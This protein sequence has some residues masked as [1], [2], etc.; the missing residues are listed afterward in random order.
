MMNLTAARFRLELEALEGMNLPPY[1]GSTFRGGF[2]GVFR[3]IACSRRLDKCNGCLLKNTCP[4]G[5]IFESGPWEGA[6]VWG[7]FE[8]I[9]RPF[10]IEP[11]ETAQTQF[12]AGERIDFHLVLIGKAIDYLPYFILVFKELGETGIGKGRAKFRLNRVVSLP[13][14]GMDGETVYD[15]ERVSNRVAVIRAADLRAEGERGDDWLHLVFQTMTRLKIDGAFVDLPEFPVLVRALLRR[16]SALQYFYCGERLECDFNA[17]IAWA[18]EVRLTDNQTFW[19]DWERYSSRQD[20][21]MHMGGLVGEAEYQGPWAEFG[22]LL[23]W[24]EVLH[25]GKGA[26]FGLGKYVIRQ[27]TP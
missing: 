12:S 22:E 27:L 6:E 19:V 5:F 7:K 23:Q 26:T 14:G 21:R 11:P 9:P 16:L 17:L 4:Y 25:V 8:E 18:G 1:K 2:G 24:G 13:V 20:T 10:V 3:R 15:G